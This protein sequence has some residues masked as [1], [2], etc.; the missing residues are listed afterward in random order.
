[1]AESDM[2]RT[3]DAQGEMTLMEHLTELRQRIIRSALAV[4]TGAIV[5]FIFKDQLIDLLMEPYCNSLPPADERALVTQENCNL[6]QTQPLEGFSLVLTVAGYG[7]LMLA[8]PV[9][10]WHMWKFIVPGL[11]PHE[12]RYA[13]P[14]VFVAATLFFSGSALA[15][16][17]APRALIFL[18]DIGGFETLLAPAPYISFLVKMLLAFGLAFQFPLV[19][20]LLQQIG[21]VDVSQLRA[22]RRY[23]VVGIVVLVAVLTPSG[24]PWTLMILSIPM[25]IFYEAAIIWGWLRK[26]KKRKSVTAS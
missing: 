8:M 13:L 18:L 1:M 16:W 5:C 19:L 4:V 24:D 20:I 22:G 15:Y 23:A 26:R 7:G 9:V 17:S 2:T 25:Y 12:K 11:Y 14:F 10:L 3:D 21:V 6:V